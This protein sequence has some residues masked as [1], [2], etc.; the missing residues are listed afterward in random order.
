MVYK[1]LVLVINQ[2]EL[3]CIYIYILVDRLVYNL[4]THICVQQLYWWLHISI[5]GILHI[6]IRPI[7][8]ASIFSTVVIVLLAL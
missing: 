1:S 2:L 5:L 6:Y 4:S 7:V 3:K 8:V